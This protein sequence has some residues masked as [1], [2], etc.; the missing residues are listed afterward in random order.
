M[1]IITTYTVVFLVIVATI[2]TLMSF[3]QSP[4]KK[5]VGQW[6]EKSWEYERVNKVGD[7]NSKEITDDVKKI[8]GQHL[9][10]HEAETWQFLPNGKLLLKAG[11]TERLVDWKIKGR[12]HI[13]QLKYDDNVVENYNLT[14]LD[15]NTMILNFDS[16][17]QARGI[18]KLTFEKS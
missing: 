16:E 18:A 12:G 4:E 7:T 13:L 14:E 10:I 2:F 1:K 8:I 5:I 9:L 11:S 6:N 15:N 17:I 3:S